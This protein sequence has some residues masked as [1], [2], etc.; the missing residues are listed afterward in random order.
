M[1]KH[2]CDL[3]GSKEN[4]VLLDHG[5][6]SLSSDRN[7]LLIPLKK[8]QCKGCGLV[9]SDTDSQNRNLSKN[10]KRKYIYNFSKKGDAVFF[11]NVGTQD[12]SSYI[13]EWVMRNLSKLELEKAETIV[14]VGC[15]EGNLLEKFSKNF[16]N[17]TI[18]GFELNKNAI[19]IGQKKGLDVRDLDDIKKVKAD[20][21]ISFAVIEHT[22]S[23]KNFLK[24]LIKSL[25]S[26]GILIIGQPHQ[27]KIYY[28]IFFSDHLFHFSSKHLEDYGR[29]LNLIQYKKSIGKWPIDS[30]SLHLF[31]KSK[32][33]LKKNTQY[34][35][36][37]VKQSIDYYKKK[38]KKINVFLQKEKNIQNGIAVFGLGE[39]FSV[40]YCYSNL[41]NANI[42]F[43]ID[44]FPKKNHDF[45]FKVISSKMIKNMKKIPIIVCVNRNYYG[46]VIKRLSTY[47]VWFPL[48]R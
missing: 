24:N 42:K 15:G 41:K 43:G 38:F 23:P 45:K 47:H 18:I 22:Q 30:F 10:Y 4:D 16:K 28:D 14:E 32:R 3:C 1:S 2:F 34:H 19:K 29:Q 33:N 44:D 6:P 37:K 9:F 20:I 39:L 17:K 7:I 11:T 46:I 36:T 21:I 5:G 26:D 35:P 27:D 25:K 48:K 40:F 31:K 12:R 13:F 8:I